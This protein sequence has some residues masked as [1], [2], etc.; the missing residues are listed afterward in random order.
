M[1]VPTSQRWTAS[2][3]AGVAS[4]KC[5]KRVNLRRRVGF[6]MVVWI[7]SVPIDERLP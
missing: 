1:V 4:E 2:S 7:L 3:L 5:V 6:D